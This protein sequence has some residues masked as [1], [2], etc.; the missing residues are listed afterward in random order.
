V[1]TFEKSDKDVKD[2]MDISLLAINF[3]KVSP[4]ESSRTNFGKVTIQ[5]SGANNPLWYVQNGELIDITADKQPIGKHDNRKPFSSHA[6]TLQTNT[7]FYLF[8]DGFADQFGGPKGKKFKYK[9]FEEKLLAISAQPM[10]EQ[11]KS[12]EQAFDNW[13]GTVEQVD[14]VLVIGIKI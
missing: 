14:D 11:K 7:T 4:K 3:S 2:G 6:I 8:T 10:E 13:K 9:Q 12:L 1:E 5:W